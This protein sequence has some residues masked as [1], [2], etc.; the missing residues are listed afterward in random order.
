MPAKKKTVKDVTTAEAF[1]IESHW[2]RKD[3]EVIAK[4]LKLPQPLV[5]DYI[6]KLMDAGKAPPPKAK[7]KSG[8][9]K[10]G[11]AVSPGTVSM[12]QTASQRADE[13]AGTSPFADPAQQSEVVRQ[14]D[15]LARKKV[16]RHIHVMNPD[17]PTT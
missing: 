16:A 17:L 5:E 7:A 1:Y 11:F 3:V 10:A 4:D 8:A 2:G 14:Q 13:L 12:T 15:E 6:A 9:E